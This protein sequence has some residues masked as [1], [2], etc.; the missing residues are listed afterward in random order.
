MSVFEI[1]GDGDLVAVTGPASLGGTAL[2]VAWSPDGSMLA[3]AH[4]GTHGL[5]VYNTSTW[6][7]LPATSEAPSHSTE[8]SVAWS[9]DGQ[10]LTVSTVASPYLMNFDVADWSRMADLEPPIPGAVKGLSYASFA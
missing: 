4:I 8:A 7:K 3:V 2:D 6:T 9:P 10:V 1:N 5:T